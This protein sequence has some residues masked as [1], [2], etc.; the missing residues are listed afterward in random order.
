[1][2]YLFSVLPSP[3]SEFI[4]RLEQILFK[5][6][7]NG[8]P[9]KIKRDILY[10]SKE[11]GGLKMTNISKFIDALKIAWVKRYLDDENKASWKTLFSNELFKIG[12]DSIWLC[13]P[14]CHT[15][16]RYEKI[17]NSFLC[18]VIKAWFKLKNMYDEKNDEVLWYNSSIKINRKTI[19]YNSWSKEGINFISDLIIENHW[20]TYDEFKNRFNVNCNF[21]K[22]F[23]VIHAVST[24]FGNQL[25]ESKHNRVSQLLIQ[26]KHAS[27]ASSFTYQLM[28]Q[29]NVDTCIPTAQYRWTEVYETETGISSELIDWSKIYSMPYK[30]TIETKCHYFQFRFIHR[31]LPTNEFLFKIGILE[32]SKCSF[33]NE[34]IE[35]MKH[36]MWKCK[37]VAS[38]WREVTHWLR[39]LNIILN[40]TYMKICLGIY[41]TDYSTFVNMLLILAKKYIYRCR[42]QETKVYFLDFKDWI[43]FIEKVEKHIAIKKDKQSF[44]IK[45]WDPLMRNM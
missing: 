5:F 41:D 9:D 27:K 11:D 16:F 18:D 26:L 7:W 43:F 35:T 17:N 22:Y 37:H 24:S 31:I 29:K 4:K 13:K 3:P 14:K 23:S 20:M 28:C 21:L 40:I 34:E 1:M 45:K 8:K 15:D 39:D 32:N 25:I 36:L 42:V 44:H 10:C 6:I 33:C 38:F 12:G 30:C 19:Y 2:T